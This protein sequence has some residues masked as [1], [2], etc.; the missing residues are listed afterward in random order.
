MRLEAKRIKEYWKN[1]KMGGKRVQIKFI[2]DCFL[3][4]CNFSIPRLTKSWRYPL[5]PAHGFPIVYLLSTLR[6]FITLQR[7]NRIGLPGKSASKVPSYFLNFP[8]ATCWADLD[9]KCF[10]H[11][12]LTKLSSMKQGNNRCLLQPLLPVF[13]LNRLATL[14]GLYF[15]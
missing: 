9:L 14:R 2:T 6:A 7:R 3:S 10:I 13:L 8:A 4:E 12:Y 15:E 5:N 1:G 11:R